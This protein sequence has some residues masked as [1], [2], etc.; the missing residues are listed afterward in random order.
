[1]IKNFHVPAISDAFNIQFRPEMFNL[2][3]HANF[4]PP[5]A[6][7]TLF[8]ATGA[9]VNGPGQITNTV[10]TARQIQFALKLLF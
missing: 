9:P 10:T 8:S 5:L 2:M 4:G 3:N 6:N 1:M 7:R